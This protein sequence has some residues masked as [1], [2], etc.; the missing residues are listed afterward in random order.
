MD[1]PRASKDQ[2][3][4]TET[5][6]SI[7]NGLISNLLIKESPHYVT[8]AQTCR[9]VSRENECCPFLRYP[10]DPSITS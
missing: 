9:S 7:W 4:R 2:E 10:G 6:I 3:I 1:R 5:T 8:V